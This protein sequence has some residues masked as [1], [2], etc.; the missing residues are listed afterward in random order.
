[1][2][3]RFPG[4]GTRVSHS[5]SDGIGAGGFYR[6]VVRAGYGSAY[7][8][9]LA[10]GV[11]AGTLQIEDLGQ[12]TGLPDEEV[13]RP[14]LLTLVAR[15]AA[16]V[17]MGHDA[18]RV[19]VPWVEVDFDVVQCERH[20]HCLTGKPKGSAE[21]GSGVRESTEATHGDG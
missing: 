7:L 14:G 17:S 16:E 5:G 4:F 20:A 12:Q 18:F 21:V 2:A 15:E 1:M 6:G 13:A 19:M 10:S 9:A 11:A 8:R 3:N